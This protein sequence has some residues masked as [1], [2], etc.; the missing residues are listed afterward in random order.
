MTQEWINQFNHTKDCNYALHLLHA[1]L[2]NVK[3]NYGF[4]SELCHLS[5][6][7]L[8]QPSRTSRRNYYNAVFDRIFVSFNSGMTSWKKVKRLGCKFS[9]LLPA[10]QILELIYSTGAMPIPGH[11]TYRTWRSSTADGSQ[12][13]Q[14]SG[15]RTPLYRARNED[16]QFNP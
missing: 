13:E 3:Q 14:V 5:Q 15:H 1:H 12:Q 11:F 8:M 16:G 6:V 2:C 4:S 9:A 7:R 10:R